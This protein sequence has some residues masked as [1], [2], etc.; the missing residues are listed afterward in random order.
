MKLNCLP[1]IEISVQADAQEPLAEY[2]GVLQLRAGAN[3]HNLA[4]PLPITVVITAISD[5]GLPPDPGEA[6][7]QTVLGIDSDNDGVRDDIQRYI[8]FTYPNEPN[9]RSALTQMARKSQGWFTPDLSEEAAYDIS[10]E[11]GTAAECLWYVGGENAN[12]LRKSLKAE[13]LNT[14]ARSRQYLEYDKLLAGNFFSLS[15]L[16]LD[17]HYKLCD[18]ELQ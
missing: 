9:I 3:Q 4:K 12:E 5:D 14:L 8:Y 13:I 15:R 6:G 16:P 18:F 11:S 17:E 10:V 7:K 2:G 1:V